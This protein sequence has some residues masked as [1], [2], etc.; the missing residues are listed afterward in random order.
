MHVEKNVCDSLIGTLLHI[1]GKTKDGINARLDLQD[2]GIRPRL[3]PVI[4]D[5]GE[6]AYLPPAS[7]TLSKAEK[8]SFCRCLHGIKVPQGYSSNVW[9]LVSMDDLKLVGLKSH[10]HHV[11]MQQLIPVAIRGVMRDD[12]RSTITRLCIFF[13]N[14]CRRSW[15][16]DSWTNWKR[17][18]LSSYPS[19]R[20]ISPAFFDIMVHLVIHLVREI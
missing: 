20:C 1:T 18:G 8:Q 10:D 19:W 7:Y 9:N 13:N 15:T 3:H 14:V 4:R 17:R 5:D 12:V 2:M 16:Q 11:L 6:K